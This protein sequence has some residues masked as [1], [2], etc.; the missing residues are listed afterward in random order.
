MNVYEA[1]AARRTIRDFDSRPIDR[2]ILLRVLD[3]GMKA[4]TNNHLRQWHFI[5]VE[6]RGRRETLARFFFTERTEE[7]VREVIDSWD[8]DVG[9]Q[10]DMYLDAI[11]K[12]ASMV[13]GAAELL[14]PCFR[15][16]SDL[17]GAKQGLHELN[18]FAS[19]WAVIENIL[20][21]AASEGIFGVTKIISAPEERDHIRSTLGIPDEFEVPCYL[22]LGYPAAEAVHHPQIPVN[23]ADRLYVDRWVGLESTFAES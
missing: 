12:Q 20:I 6:S 19:M 2:E 5:R 9:S 11:P 22:P 18:G 21:A 7:E 16:E 3:A 23:A 17:L 1:I 14:I 10:Y 8:M 15:Q 4:P 13:I